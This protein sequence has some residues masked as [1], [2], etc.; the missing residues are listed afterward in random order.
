[1]I[2]RLISF[3]FFSDVQVYYNAPLLPDTY[4]TAFQRMMSIDDYESLGWIPATKTT[5]SP[6]PARE[7]NLSTILWSVCASL[8]VLIVVI[9]FIVVYIMKRNKTQN[10]DID[11]NEARSGNAFGKMARS[12]SIHMARLHG[13]SSGIVY[14]RCITFI[15]LSF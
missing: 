9:V 13:E 8:V 12:L 15:L 2:E 3:G 10:H 1:M 6:Q 14:S 11:G 7:S 4:Y 5:I